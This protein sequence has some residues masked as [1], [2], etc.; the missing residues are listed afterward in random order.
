MAQYFGLSNFGS[1]NT[2]SVQN[3]VLGSAWDVFF[4]L[5]CGLT[6]DLFVLHDQEEAECRDLGEF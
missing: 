6:S 1:Q 3:V 5:L 4:F 2:T